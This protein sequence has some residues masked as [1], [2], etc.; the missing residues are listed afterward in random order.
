MAVHPAGKGKGKENRVW[1]S[2]DESVQSMPESPT[3]YAAADPSS[4]LLFSVDSLLHP[5]LTCF[6]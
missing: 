5:E 4:Y 1:E 3:S 2:G 6:P